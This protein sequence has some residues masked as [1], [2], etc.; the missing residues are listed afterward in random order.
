MPGYLPKHVPGDTVTTRAASPILGGQRVAVAGSGTV[1]T[2]T[3]ATKAKFCG[4]AAYDAGTNAELTIYGR[5]M[6]HI[7]IA[8]GAIAAG[9]FVESA[10]DGKVAAVASGVGDGIAL[11]T[12]A[13]GA[14]CEWMEL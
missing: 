12:A 1:A 13:D 7:T 11:T 10:N 8:A 9:A 3:A 5:G 4:V 14:A 2:A 6:V